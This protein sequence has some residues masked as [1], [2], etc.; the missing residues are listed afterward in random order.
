MTM[1]TN[2]QNRMPAKE[3]FTLRPGGP[4]VVMA[5]KI[6]D[7]TKRV[8]P[9]CESFTSWRA[10]LC[11]GPRT[12]GTR[13]SASLQGDANHPSP[14][15]PCVVMAHEC[16]GRDEARPSM[17]VY[18]RTRR[19]GSLRPGRIPP[20]QFLRPTRQKRRSLG[21][22]LW[23]P[24]CPPRSMSAPESGGRGRSVQSD[25]GLEKCVELL[26]VTETAAQPDSI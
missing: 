12:S 10:T 5:P 24:S 23:S 19:S 6:R 1:K 15:G 4:R 25:R 14:G 16:H 21:Q 13:R 11:R 22:T 2:G 3:F 8:S 17:A 9:P 20:G 7:A 26:R 18:S